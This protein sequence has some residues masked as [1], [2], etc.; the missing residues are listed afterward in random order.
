MPNIINLRLLDNKSVVADMQG[1]PLGSENSYKIVAG[2]KNATKF[3]IISTPLKYQSATYTV[4][5]VNSKGY[6]VDIEIKDNEFTLPIGMAISGYGYLQFECFQNEEEVPFLPFKIKVWE[7][8]DGWENGISSKGVQANPNQESTEE[9]NSILIDGTVYSIPKGGEGSGIR[10]LETAP[11]T[12]TEGYVGE[13]VQV[14]DGTA[15]QCTAITDGAYEWK[16]VITTKN[17]AE[18]GKTYN[19]ARGRLGLVG[20][21]HIYN[22]G[23]QVASNG[24]L[25]VWSPTNANHDNVVT[26]KYPYV[27]VSFLNI[28]RAVQYALSNADTYTQY[29]AQWKD[30]TRQKARHTLGIYT[31]NIT[32]TFNNEAGIEFNLNFEIHNSQSTAY[33]EISQVIDLALI[34]KRSSGSGGEPIYP[35]IAFW[36]TGFAFVYLG[37]GVN[38]STQPQSVN[39]SACTFVDTVT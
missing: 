2:E 33:T 34:P 3:K 32:I 11:T 20:L 10:T 13:I 30:T 37:A 15:Y 18:Q 36:D 38:F 39:F 14:S 25:S 17:V 35:I 6:R 27:P 29:P 7:T 21:Q 1:I 24:A 19:G 9:L 22:S 12:T 16:K 26:T 5:G 28:A 8:I 31:H 4:Y 23:L